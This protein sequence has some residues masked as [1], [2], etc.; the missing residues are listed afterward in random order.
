MVG[1]V[2]SEVDYY[3]DMPRAMEGDPLRGRYEAWDKS[4]IDQALGLF[5]VDTVR[6][7]STSLG[8]RKKSPWSLRCFTAPK[9]LILDEP[10]SGLDSFDQ[11]KR[12]LNLWW[13]KPK[14]RYHLFLQP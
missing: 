13:R 12:W 6:R 9:L 1:Y 14:G 5:E 2:P 3:M 8:N 4:G 11:A 10:T 7:I